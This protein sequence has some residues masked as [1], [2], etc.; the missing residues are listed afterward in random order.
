[1]H[2]GPGAACMTGGDLHLIVEQPFTSMF[3]DRRK[4]LSSV[5]TAFAS[6]WSSSFTREESQVKMWITQ[7]LQRIQLDRNHFHF[8]QRAEEMANTEQWPVSDPDTAASADLK[9]KKGVAL[10]CSSPTNYCYFSHRNI[11]QTHRCAIKKKY[12]K[13]IRDVIAAIKLNMMPY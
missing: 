10:F 9:I 2:T 1:M 3:N 8:H 11:A 13:S 4:Q 12:L 7:Y 5:R 6:L